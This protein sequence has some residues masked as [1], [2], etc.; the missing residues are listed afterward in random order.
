MN[1]DVRNRLP[2]RFAPFEDPASSR[3]AAQVAR[4]SLSSKAESTRMANEQRQSQALSATSATQ[5]SGI[6]WSVRKS[7]R[8]KT[9]E[10]RIY[11]L[12]KIEVCQGALGTKTPG[13]EFSQVRQPRRGRNRVLVAGVN[14]CLPLEQLARIPSRCLAE[15]CDLATLGPR[16]RAPLVDPNAKRDGFR[17]SD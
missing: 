17:L 4:Q 6:P 10:R 12:V 9:D 14:P 3:A 8:G 1:R 15:I 5:F 13:F 11:E 2:R 7:F 16:R